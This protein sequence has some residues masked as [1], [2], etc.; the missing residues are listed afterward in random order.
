MS[1]KTDVM[2]KVIGFLTG[3]RTNNN[4]EWFAANKKEYQAAQ[5]EFNAFVAQLIDGISAFDDSV[6]G[7]AAKDCVFRIYRDVRFSKNKEPYK[8]HMGAFISPGGRNAGNAGYYFHVEPTSDGM[9]GSSILS[10]G[11]YMPAPA[12]VKSIRE[13]I[14]YNGDEFLAAAAK[15]DDF[16][17][18]MR[19]ALKRVPAGYP[20]DSPMAEY[21]KMKDDMSLYRYVDNKFLTS[22]KLL[23]RVVAEYEK[24]ADFVRW[25]NR[26][27]NFA[28]EEM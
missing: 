8:T 22:P 27:V 21:L 28:R 6:R 11:I 19:S 26:A 9:I 12:A 25:L 7:L 14:M 17:F 10:A 2:Q 3:L 24:T 16:V 23:E 20:A 13:D 18:D 1:L 15:A 5:E 4:R